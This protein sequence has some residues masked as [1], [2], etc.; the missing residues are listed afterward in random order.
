MSALLPGAPFLGWLI[1]ALAASTL[2]MGLAL[3]IRRPVRE[4][5]GPQIAYALWALPL[6]RLL[7]PPLPAG[8]RQA[9]AT[10][11]AR[12][13]RRSRSWSWGRAPPRSRPPSHR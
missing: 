7:L 5:F 8:L 10:P 9:A 2:L 1:E 6:L 13:A 12:R 11:S 3:L 4:A